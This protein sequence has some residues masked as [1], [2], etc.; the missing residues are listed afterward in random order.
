MDYSIHKI[1][2]DVN[3]VNFISNVIGRKSRKFIICNGFIGLVCFE[4]ALDGLERS[5][6][7][8]SKKD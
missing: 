1:F 6:Q 5:N 2:L 8:N 3:N 7:V 4:L